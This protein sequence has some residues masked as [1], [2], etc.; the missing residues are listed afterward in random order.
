M[1]SLV[2]VALISALLTGASLAQVPNAESPL[3]NTAVRFSPGTVIRAELAKSVDAK[4]AKVGDEVLAKTMDDFFSD[5]NE[6]L[7]PKGSQVLA[8]VV[9][10]S[11]HQGNSPSTLGI[12]FDK[13]VLKNGTEVPL[14]AS[15]QAIGGPESNAAAFNDP[16]A[17][18]A[19][20]GTPSMSSPGRGAYG[21]TA[22]NPGGVPA[23]ANPT[24]Q[25]PDTTSGAAINGRLA[26]NAQGVVGISGLSLSTGAAQDSL[27]TS[28]KHN[29]KLDSG[30]QM[31]LHVIP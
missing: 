25:I 20:P 19:A 11:P 7:A 1:K 5:K 21:G 6:V 8:H 15:I 28:P 13:I 24:G 2:K 30:T 31:I 27:L 4:K 29:V 18:S 23:S 22:P 26:P 14:K 17:A 9:E 16:M 10:V 3:Q 12:A